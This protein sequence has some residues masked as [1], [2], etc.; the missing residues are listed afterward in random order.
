M[1][2]RL[3]DINLV[4]ELPNTFEDVKKQLGSDE[5]RYGDTWKE[6]GLVFNEQTQEQR[7]FIKMQEYYQDY[8]ENGQPIPW[9]KVIGEAHICKVREKILK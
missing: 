2:E 3:K 5:L 9:N 7:W 4:D 6:R 8:I 1:D